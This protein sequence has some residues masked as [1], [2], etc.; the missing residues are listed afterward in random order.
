MADRD[1]DI[2]RA[3]A[4][5]TMAIGDRLSAISEPQG[6][7][8]AVTD[9]VLARLD[10]ITSRLR[11]QFDHLRTQGSRR[12][13]DAYYA[14]EMETENELQ[15]VSAGL[16]AAM[17]LAG[18]FGSP[19]EIEE[20]LAA[21]LSPTG[22][23]ARRSEASRVPRPPTRPAAFEWSQVPIPWAEDKDFA[24]PPEGA[25]ALAQ[26]RQFVGADAERIRVDEA[27]YAQWVQLGFVERQ[28]TF[29]TRY[30]KVPS[31]QI[32][33]MSGL[34]VSDGAP[35]LNSAP[36]SELPPYLWESPFCDLVPGMDQERAR[37]ALRGTRQP[38]AGLVSFE[39]T[40]GAPATSRGLGLNQ[41]CL[42]PQLEIVALLGLRP[43][44]PALRH[45]LIDDIGPGIVCR[46]WRSHLIHDGRYGPMEP[47]VQ[48]SDLL[49][50]PDLFEILEATVG[51]DRMALGFT[52]RHD[53]GLLPDEDT[54]G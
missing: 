14:D 35:P 42:T 8:D 49:I 26:A 39:Q 36:L 48:G 52:V 10:S 41:F 40:S 19:L 16:R 6:V 9:G 46:Q 28:L 2:Q 34:E 13:P 15:K 25:T 45:V 53:Q 50:R 23:W 3:Q 22:V 12:I 20:Y 1:E 4:M 18:I 27:P 17:A 47:A 33:L 38:L 31:R 29:A 21:E 44:T 24:W 7:R 37:A 11:N 51:P 54:D 30:P 32:F 5:V 43:E